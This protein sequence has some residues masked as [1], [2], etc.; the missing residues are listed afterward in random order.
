[1]NEATLSV[2]V[3]LS[4]VVSTLA[5]DPVNF[6][7]DVRP[8]L[9]DKCFTCHGPDAK[10]VEGDLR[11]DLHDSAARLD[12]EG[13]AAVVPGKP[14]ASEL[15][16]RIISDDPDERMPPEQSNK[17]LS[18][19]EKEL[20]TRWIAEGAEYK[21]HWAFLAP[22]GHV[23]PPVQGLGDR[24]QN[25][26][27]AFVVARLQKEGLAMAPEADKATLIRRVSL[28]LT[29]LPPTPAEVET[30]QNDKSDR[31]YERVVD[32][33]LASP[34]FAERMAMNWLD[35]ARYADTHGLQQ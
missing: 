33:L 4:G 16:R 19:A 2:I 34:R 9:S 30:F 28:D 27:D 32:R 31:A 23:P 7:R 15:V 11:L 20:L 24:I 35:L 25:P 5:A 6:N 10:H 29:G 12:E 17:K 14:E 21:G 26:I 8:I 3:V 13:H 18:P 22:T 1:M